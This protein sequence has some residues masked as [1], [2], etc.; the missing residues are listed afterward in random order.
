MYNTEIIRFFCFQIKLIKKIK[1]NVKCLLL[2]IDQYEEV[3]FQYSANCL[4]LIQVQTISLLYQNSLGILESINLIN[5]FTFFSQVRQS[6][7]DSLILRQRQY[8]D[9]LWDVH[10]IDINAQEKSLTNGF[11]LFFQQSLQEQIILLSPEQIVEEAK[12][13][14]ITQR[15]LFEE[16]MGR[17]S[18][19][20]TS[21]DY[22]K[23]LKD[24]MNV[25]KLFNR[26]HLFQMGYC[27]LLL[28]STWGWILIVN[29]ST[30]NP[31]FDLICSVLSKSIQRN[32]LFQKFAEMVK[33][34][35]N[36]DAHVK[37]KI[38]PRNSKEVPT[39]SF[40]I[41]DCLS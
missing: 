4:K 1:K 24:Q 16:W 8:R 37:F 13:D 10:E 27:K 21:S 5:Y 3:T 41:S 15:A 23:S 35:F 40:F 22:Q 2:L 19:L 38:M 30:P 17:F 25:K 33:R 28:S 32:T 14:S 34:E 6:G 26:F 12:I 9:A 18:F 39:L 7:F 31:I 11:H 29:Y 20:Q 36:P